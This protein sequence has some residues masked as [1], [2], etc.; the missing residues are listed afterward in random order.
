MFFLIQ[1]YTGNYFIIAAEPGVGKML[2]IPTVGKSGSFKSVFL[3]E[4]TEFP[5]GV[6]YKATCQIWQQVRDNKTSDRPSCMLY[7]AHLS[8]VSSVPCQIWN[9]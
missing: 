2:Q 8:P 4:A 5:S 3:A 1:I 6:C 7:F 9:W